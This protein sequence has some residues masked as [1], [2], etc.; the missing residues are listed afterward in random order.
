MRFKLII[1][2]LALMLFSASGLAL[3]MM[4]DFPPEVISQAEREKELTQADIDGFAKMWPS[5]M[6]SNGNM[7]KEEALDLYTKN[8]FTESRGT[9]VIMKIANART[10]SAIVKTT[11]DK[12]MA[13]KMLQGMKMPLVFI[14]TDAEIEL[15]QK[16][17]AKIDALPGM[18]QP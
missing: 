15:V 3:A 1:C 10:I 4:P 2:A 8:G 6:A 12:S 7:P 16:N 14:P 9:Y 13:V 18:V 17:A 5:I 11:N